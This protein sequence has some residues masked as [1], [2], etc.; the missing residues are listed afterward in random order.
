MNKARTLTV[1]LW[2]SAIVLLAWVLKDMPI[3]TMLNAVGA[4]SIGQWG[5]WLGVN[6]LVLALSTQRWLALIRS[7]SGSVP[8]LSLLL[9]RLGGQFVSFVTPGPQ[10]GGEPLQVYWLYKRQGLP[11]HKAILSLGVDRF[12]ELWVNF[13]VLLLGAI[14][15]LLSPGMAFADWG[16]IALVLTLLLLAIPLLIVLLLKRPQWISTRLQTLFARWLSHPR[17]AALNA[18]QESLKRELD[19]LVNLRRAVLLR[20]LLTSLLTWVFILAELWLL[21]S[22][23]GVAVEPQGFAL[24]AVAIRLAMLLPLPGGIGTIEAALLWSMQQLG[25]TVADA[26]ALI[27]LM[28]LRDTLILFAGAASLTLLR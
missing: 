8:V 7:L 18:H 21:L 16:Q 4:L 9:I 10:F 15:L 20:G 17:L 28:R 14:L 3:G 1:L 26:F 24:I 13:A 11:L 19:M 25:F 6:L 5:L 22:F 23:I 2:I 12:L 27:V